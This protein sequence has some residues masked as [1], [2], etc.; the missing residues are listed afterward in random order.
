V[1]ENEIYVFMFLHNF[2]VKLINQRIIW[3]YTSV[4]PMKKV[5]L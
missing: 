2:Y 1:Y 4:I 3:S 5:Q